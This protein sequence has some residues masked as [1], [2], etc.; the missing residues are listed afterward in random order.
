MAYNWLPMPYCRFVDYIDYGD[1]VKEFAYYGTCKTYPRGP[2]MLIDDHGNGTDAGARAY[3]EPG[4]AVLTEWMYLVWGHPLSY[5]AWAMDKLVQQ[6]GSSFYYQTPN[7]YDW[8]V[9]GEYYGNYGPDGTQ[10][11]SWIFNTLNEAARAVN[12]NV[13][14][15][16]PYLS[17]ASRDHWNQFGQPFLYLETPATA[18]VYGALVAAS[19]DYPALVQVAEMVGPGSQLWADSVEAANARKDAHKKIS[20]SLTTMFVLAVASFGAAAYFAPAT[21]AEGGAVAAGAETGGLAAELTAEQWAAGLTAEQI[22][23]AV[24][25]P[26]LLAEELT[27]EQW[28]AGVST[29]EFA[30]TAPG[31]FD[32][33]ESLPSPPSGT[34]SV[35]TTTPST[36]ILSQAGGAATTAAKSLVAQQ[37]QQALMNDPDAPLD[38]LAPPP[39]KS[40]IAVLLALGIVGGAM[41]LRK[42]RK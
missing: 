1:F 29:E 2:N 34:P 31:V 8:I 15:W 39:Q 10:G 35:P 5:D 9:L 17:I 36:D 22:T 30:G 3:G 16:T 18:P 12:V 20:N 38:G 41:V 42:A 21:A 7:W 25:L 33:A 37:I 6:F 4:T 28:A 26:E 32:I 23:G 14:D 13:P 24:A 19:A 11:R 27:A 40:N